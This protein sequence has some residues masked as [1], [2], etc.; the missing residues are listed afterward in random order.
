VFVYP[1]PTGGQFQVR[2]YSSINDI[3]PKGINIFD[4]R[5]K[6]LITQTYPI[7]APYSRMD[8]DLSNYSTGVYTVEVVDV[9]GNRLAIGRV[10]VIR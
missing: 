9:N 2:Y 10:S 3:K 6:R 1:N 4:G 8:V 7:T 5:G